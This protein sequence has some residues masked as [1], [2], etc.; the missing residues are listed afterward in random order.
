MI[1]QALEMAWPVIVNIILALLIVAV[2]WMASEWADRTASRALRSSGVSEALAR[3]VVLLVFRPLKIDDVVIP[4]GEVTNGV[5]QNSTRRGMRR[6]S[7]DIGVEYGSDL[8]RVR[9]TLATAADQL[10]L[11][12]SDAV[13]V[14]QAAKQGSPPASLRG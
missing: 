7:V 8:D 4:N 6:I 12:H 2:G 9:Q 5:I 3:G 14:A 11:H 10:V 1:T 13:E